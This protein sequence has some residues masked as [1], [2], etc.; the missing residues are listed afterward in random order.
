MLG[1]AILRLLS[2]SDQ[3][4]VHGSARSAGLPVRFPQKLG[5]RVITG[6]DV[7]NPDALMRLFSTVRPDVVINCVG[8]VKQLAEAKDPLAA[9]PINSILPH[10]LA[11][12]CE[13]AGARLIHF[14]TDCVF[15]GSR[16][17]YQESDPADAKDLYGRSKYLGEVAYSNCLTLR[18]SIIGHELN[19]ARSLIGWFLS[20]SGRVKGFSKAV[21]SG[22]PT[23]EVA[24]VL[25]DFVIPKPDLSGLYHLS[26]EPISK[27]DLLSLVAEIYAKEIE[28]QPDD[29]FVIDRSLNSERF[30]KATGYTPS[31]WRTMIETMRDFG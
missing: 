31:S 26:A 28:I 2:Q 25:R 12:F 1:N 29:S 4:E 30:R 7:E 17:M 3:L 11:R 23:V 16:G 8:L 20:Q 5:G 10:R 19:S 21:F 9:L 18:T 22:L 15:S 27:F 14:S 13:L 24:K 6:V